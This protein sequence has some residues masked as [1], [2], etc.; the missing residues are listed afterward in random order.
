[1]TVWDKAGPIVQH[2][3]AE[4]ITGLAPE[5]MGPIRPVL[6]K[7]L[8]EL[9]SLRSQARRATTRH[10]HGAPALPILVMLSQRFAPCDRSAERAVPLI[11]Q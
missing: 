1:M 7:I 4:R 11:E 8:S 10:S 9:L 2:I 5:Q 6:L 3:L